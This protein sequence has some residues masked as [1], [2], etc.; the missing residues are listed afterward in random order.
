[1]SL[2]SGTRLALRPFESLRVVPSLVEGRQ[3]QGDL[4]QGRKVGVYEVIALVGEGGPAFARV[5]KTA[6]RHGGP[7]RTK[8]EERRKRMGLKQ[9]E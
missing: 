7:G 5:T 9:G 6:A 2:A 8:T 1:M 4:E 3:A